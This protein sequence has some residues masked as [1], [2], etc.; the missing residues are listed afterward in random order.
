MIYSRTSVTINALAEQRFSEF[1]DEYRNQLKSEIESQPKDYI[2]KIVENEYTQYLIEKYTL[3]ELAVDRVD[4]ETLQPEKIYFHGENH[5]GEGTKVEGY[6]ISS[7]YKYSGSPILFKMAP[8]SRTIVSHPITVN[9]EN[10]SLILSVEVYTLDPQVYSGSRSRALNDALIN[11]PNLNKEVKQWNYDLPRLVEMYFKAVKEKYLKENKFFEQINVKVNN[12]TDS[13]YSVPSIKRKIIPQ[14]VV[15]DKKVFSGVPS[16]PDSVYKDILKVI[17]DLG[18]SMEK[19]PA[20]YKDKSEEDLR[21]NILMFLET[22]YDA[23][24]ATGETFNKSGKTDILLKYQDGT[25][26]FVAECKYWD[27][28]V[29]MNDA[30]DQLFD[31]YLTWRDSK[32]ALILFVQRV[33]FSTVLSTIKEEAIKHKYY[34]K[35]VNTKDDSSFAYEFHFPGDKAKVIQL[36]IMAFHFKK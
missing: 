13:I 14:P 1:T 28:A 2:L 32:A 25:N 31:R 16:F 27:G 3:N 15:S 36:E 29:V 8:G 7:V 6:R 17:H 11:I 19:K 9:S 4:F 26:L 10:N 33:D 12:D 35:E 23:T 24:T 22:R 5:R 34:L 18:K 30:I 21:D 20:T